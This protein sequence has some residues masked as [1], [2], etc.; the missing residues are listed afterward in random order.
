MLP[1]VYIWKELMVYSPDKSWI[2]YQ[3]EVTI[4][5]WKRSLQWL[6]QPHELEIFLFEM[7]LTFSFWN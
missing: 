6:A 5:R 2:D 4:K 1:T 3:A 7:W